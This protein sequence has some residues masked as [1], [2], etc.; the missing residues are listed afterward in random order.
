MPCAGVV[1]VCVCGECVVQEV[2]GH[3]VHCVYGDNGV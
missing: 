2:R 3:G 1:H